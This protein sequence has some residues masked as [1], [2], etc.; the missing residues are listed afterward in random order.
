MASQ[1]SVQQKHFA[2]LRGAL[3]HLVSEVSHWEAQGDRSSVELVL[4][5]EGQKRRRLTFGRSGGELGVLVW[6]CDP[7]PG[8]MDSMWFSMGQL[9]P[10][11]RMSAKDLKRRPFEGA[12]CEVLT[13]WNMGSPNISTSLDE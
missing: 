3:D 10:V 8:A 2:S 5:L 13:A 4:S 7:K 12:V 9:Q 11:L 6:I 1:P